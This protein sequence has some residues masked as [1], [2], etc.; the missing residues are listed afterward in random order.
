MRSA[1]LALAIQFKASPV[2]YIRPCL[3][4]RET[5]NLYKSQKCFKKNT[6]ERDKKKFTPNLT[7]FSITG[8]LFVTSLYAHIISRERDMKSLQAGVITGAH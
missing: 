7:I 2:G 1:G 6:R 4:V 8:L 5:F 3:K